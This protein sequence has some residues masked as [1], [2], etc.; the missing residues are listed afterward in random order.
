MRDPKRAFRFL[1]YSL[2][3]FVIAF[4]A[5]YFRTYSLHGGPGIPF[6][7]SA[8]LA[9]QLVDRGIRDQLRSSLQKQFPQI[10]PSERERAV[11][12]QVQKLKSA[13]RAN[14]EAAVKNALL[15]I[16]RSRT[17]G[18]YHYLLE[19]DPYYFFGQTEKLLETGRIADTRRDGK[20]L[21]PLREAPHGHWTEILFHPYLGL[22]WYKFVRFFEPRAS[23]MKTLGFFPLLLVLLILP[24]F[25]WLGK[26]LRFPLIASA[27]GMATI[28]FSPIFIQRSA[29]GWYDT[30]PYNYVFPI[31]IL[32]FVFQGLQDRKWFWPGVLGA[33][34]LAGLYAMFWPGWA[35]IGVLIPVSIL[36]GLFGLW[37]LQRSM[38]P[39]LA[40]AA[41]RFGGIFILG[42]L[43]SAAVFL[44]PA[45]L[46]ASLNRGWFAINKFSLSDFDLWPNIFLTVGE[47][48]SITLRKLIFLTGNYV[49][50]V[51]AVAGLLWEGLHIFKRQD[52]RERFRFFFLLCFT[53]PIMFLSIKTE[54]FSVLF[55][56]P[57][58]IFAG[59]A[60]MRFV[61]WAQDSF[62]RIFPGLAERERVY[63]AVAVSLVVLLFAPLLLI[64]AHVV[65]MGIRPIMDDVWYQALKEVK[66]KTPENA[67]VDSWWPP[68]YFI[69]GIAHRR[70]VVD[71]GT[72]HLHI[73]Y[74]MAKILMAE[75]ERES[76]GL[77]RMVNTSGEDAPDLLERWGMDVP[78]AVDLILKVTRLNRIEA[79]RILPSAWTPAQKEELLDKTHGR[80]DLPPSYLLIYNDLVEQ[81]LAVTVVANWDF[82]KAKSL[83]AQK[84]KGHGGSEGMF[85]RDSGKRYVEDLIQTS[86]K[87]L[88]YTPV[89]A[90][91]QRRGDFLSFT[92]GLRVNLATHEALIFLP[93]KKLQGAPSSLFYFE[94]GQLLEKVFRG[95][96]GLDISALVFEDQG[97]FYSVLA[98]A[99]LIRSLL[100]RLYYLQ[101]RGLSLFR[102]LVSRGTLKGGTVIRVFELDREKLLAQDLGR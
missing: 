12:L 99:R 70:V 66:A 97:S 10:S 16:T 13:D 78:D 50:F 57:L 93:E 58:A 92:N 44:S 37:I 39:D 68:G 63:R 65:A 38:E 40:K 77:L 75:N 14:Y 80:G 29:L 72:Q 51:I 27:I 62:S 53:A 64:S 94:K 69:T 54:R 19:A 34:F 28:S 22:Y 6:R 9:R 81:N 47:A 33:S 4:L 24:M 26:V 83:Q 59:F 32:A 100:F 73:S 23:L 86:G 8:S 35:L 91:S 42:W 25:A 87:W 56:L 1:K 15:N 5:V 102:P 98:D 11:D 36:G 30:D 3:L 60:V 95:E 48:G 17:G 49:T 21:E 71:G 52:P 89:A 45:V 82:R 88:R 67:I 2:V 85:E 79:F 61:A 46:I 101:G 18:G 31:L 20:Y 41:L 96:G 84:R 43:I 90:L 7:S 76:A 74:W 55:V